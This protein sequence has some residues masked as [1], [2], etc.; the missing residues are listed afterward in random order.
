MFILFVFF[1]LYES[2]L[3]FL[4]DEYRIFFL[5]IFLKDHKFFS[6]YFSREISNSFEEAFP[7]IRSAET[8]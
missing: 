8:L 3:R 5:H 2:S 7:K 4:L 1:N 6:F